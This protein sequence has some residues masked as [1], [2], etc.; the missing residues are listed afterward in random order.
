[1]SSTGK[2][3][4]ALGRS[5]LYIYHP[6]VT[7]LLITFVMLGLLLLIVLQPIGRVGLINVS[8]ALEALLWPSII[9]LTLL[10]ALSTLSVFFPEF[11][12]TVAAGFLLGTLT[13][14]LFSVI[15]LT[16]CASGNFW[17][18][19]RHEN[20]V[21]HLLF[22]SHSRAEIRWT[23]TRISRVMV[24][25]TWVLPSIN[26]DLISYA[27]GLSTMRYRTFLLISI[28]GNAISSLMLAF[29]GSALRSNA[30]ILAVA[31]LFG[32]TLVGTVLYLK[33]LPP[34]FLPASLE[35]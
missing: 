7:K 31:T 2:R 8:T 3:T 18:S 32:Y 11:L 1:M 13:G 19:R 10:F 28:A 30:A 17:I 34:R 14:S 9:L 26:F 29:L 24:F 23:A 16:A 12:V 25:F 6:V 35:D 22:D 20:R 5:L 33:E 27:A 21:I 4:A 15:T